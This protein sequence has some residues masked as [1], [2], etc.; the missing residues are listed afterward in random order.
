MPLV[1]LVVAAARNGVIG[2]DNG[3]A[4]RLRSDLR[5]FRALTMGKPILMGRRTFASI[6]KAL[7]GRRNIV[8]TR[9]RSFEAPEIVAIHDWEAALAAA[10][11]APELMVVGGAEIYRMAL[12]VAD[13][14]H[15]TEVDAEPEGDTFLPEYDRAAYRETLRES[16][17]PGEGDEHAFTYIDLERT[18]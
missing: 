11:D 14:I 5:R 2:R 15:L 10:G 4:W 7:P 13:R 16:H 3:L 17:A 9:D 18:R 8:L 6:G 12:P 1:T